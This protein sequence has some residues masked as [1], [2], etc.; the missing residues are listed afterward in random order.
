MK[1]VL[2]VFT[3]IFLAFATFIVGKAFFYGRW[4]TVQRTSPQRVELSYEKAM[5][6]GILSPLEIATH[7]APEVH[8]AVNVLISSSGKGGFILNSN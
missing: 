8:A 7:Y 2:K 4:T 3:I 5:T 1:R 6:D